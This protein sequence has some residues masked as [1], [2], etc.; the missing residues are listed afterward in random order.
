MG[1][2]EILV[3]FENLLN[4]LELKDVREF[5]M[6]MDQDGSGTIDLEEFFK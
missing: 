2:D 5:F 4:P 3:A 1:Y 6:M